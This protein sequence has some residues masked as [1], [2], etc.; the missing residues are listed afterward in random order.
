[1]ESLALEPQA[2]AAHLAALDRLTKPLSTTASLPS[3]VQASSKLHQEHEPAGPMSA[4]EWPAR[5][6]SH[7]QAE[8]AAYVEGGTAQGTSQQPYSQAPSALQPCGSQGAGAPGTAMLSS[9]ASQL[10]VP[11]SPAGMQ[12]LVCSLFVAGE[13][14]A[15]PLC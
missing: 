5:I 13:V 14:R 3:A 10:E 11:G 15:R 9:T 1:M 4:S 2:A 7:C 6:L 12:C 8:L